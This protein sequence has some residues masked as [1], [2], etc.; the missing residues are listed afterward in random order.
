MITPKIVRTKLAKIAKGL[1]KKI[2]M[3]RNKTRTKEKE[4]LCT[5]MER[6]NITKTAVQALAVGVG[7]ELPVNATSFGSG[8]GTAA[9][10][11]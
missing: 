7:T 4:L 8:P 9:F 3:E 11:N 6:L 10:W 5:R 1:L 2:T